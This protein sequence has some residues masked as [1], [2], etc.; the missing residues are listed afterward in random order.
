MRLKKILKPANTILHACLCFHPLFC[1][2]Q[3]FHSGIIRGGYTLNVT[4]F[5]HE[6]QHVAGSGAA[7][8]KIF[9]NVPLHDIMI[10]NQ[11]QIV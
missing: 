5:F 6:L 7:N 8:G 2:N 1:D 10:L 3:L 4:V 11:G 9:F